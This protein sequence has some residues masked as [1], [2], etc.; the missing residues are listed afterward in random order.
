MLN[1]APEQR[2]LDRFVLL[3]KIGTGGHGEVWRAH[4]S[5]RDTQVAVKVLF[6]QLARSGAAWEMLQHEYDIAQRLS[7]KSILEISEPL[8]DEQFT[9]LPMQLATGDLRRLRGD[10]YLRIV[11]ML[12]DIAGALAHA[13]ARGVIHRD[14]KPANVLV[15]EEG[16]IKLADFGAA[17]LSE[18][19]E[20]ANA[21]SPFSASPQQLAGEPATPQDDIYG[22]GALAYELLSGYPPHYPNFDRKLMTEQPVPPLQAAQPLPPRLDALVM[23]M[24]AKSPADRPASMEEVLE[25]LRTALQDTL[26]NVADGGEHPVIEKSIAL[27]DTA[28]ETL[29]L[30]GGGDTGTNQ[31]LAEERP[32]RKAW[33]WV[34]AGAAVALLAAVFLLLPRFAKAPPASAAAGKV[35]GPVVDAVEAAAQLEARRAERE[36]T[37]VTRRKA[38]EQ[39]LAQLENQQAAL[40]AGPAF[41]A[42]KSLGLDAV[43]AHEAA[44]DDIANDRLDVALKRLQKVADLAPQA[45]KAQMTEG[46][47]ALQ[48]G[49]IEAARA[50]FDRALRLRPEDRDARAGLERAARL[51]PLLPVLVQADNDLAQ[52]KLRAATEG[53]ATVLRAEPRLRRAIDGLARARGSLGTSEFQ[54]ALGNGLAALRAGK[55]DEARSALE[56][57]RVL[58]PDAPEVAA[59]FAQL[60]GRK[61][62]IS[63]ATDQQGILQLE[64]SERWADALAAYDAVLRNDASVEFA[65]AGKARVTP[66]VEL[67]RRLQSLIDQPNRLSSPAVRTETRQLLTAARATTP[68]GPV[69]RSQVAR[70]ELLIP[71]YEK[72]VRVVLESDSQTLLS[73]SSVGALGSF[74]HRE[75]ELLPGKYTLTG[76][77]DGYRDARREITVRPGDDNPV[78]ELHCTDAI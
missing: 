64:T 3:E 58:S 14:L 17:R 43:A 71:Q 72:P 49:Q 48:D 66:R 32:R 33:L 65:R 51:Q 45:Y 26:E 29:V 2:L 27:D 75:L 78:F 54:N 37:F 42:G 52:N 39:L 5:Q 25:G 56:R 40:W 35:A 68:S 13:H 62:G 41:A 20:S 28:N 10:S 77:R 50:A 7:H 23:R 53:Y 19:D 61:T 16:Q 4:D 9:V 21:G 60:E 44:K 8:R 36:Q 11:P 12:L 22:L 47:Q 76:T 18:G 30:E 31:A 63:L 1:L 46:E 38:F 55:L 67:A 57:A 15:C 34:S 24:L 73:L 69:L 70:L 74:A 59:A 6:P